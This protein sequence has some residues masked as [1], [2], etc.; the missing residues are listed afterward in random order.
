[1]ANAA[2]AS[3]YQ[4]LSL[5]KKDKVIK[6][7]GKTTSFDYYESLLSPNIT[8]IMTVIDTGGSTEYDS[9]YDSQGRDGAI[10]NGLPLTGDGSEEIRFKITNS[11]GTL[12]F[13]QNPL[14]VN[15]TINPDKESQREAIALNLVS[16][17]AITNQ[18][19]HVLR[20]YSQYTNNGEIVQAISNNLLGLQKLTIEATKN[21]YPLI[22]NDTPPFD[23]ILML[24]AKSAPETGKPGFFFYETKNGHNFR[25][26]DSLIDEGPVATY[27]R[28][29]VNKSS[30]NANNDFK[31]SS[32][33]IHKNQNLIN[34]LKS[35][36][37]TNRRITFD[38]R[39]FS[40]EEKT[41]SIGNMQVSLGKSKVPKPENDK[42]TRTVFSVKD[43]GALGSDVVEGN[44]AGDPQ[45]WQGDIQM[46]YNLLF[47][48]MVHMQVPCNPNL[49][50]GDVVRCELDI[51]SH[52]EKEQGEI[53]PVNSGDYMILDLCHHY[54]PKRSFTSMTLVRDT[55]GLYTNKN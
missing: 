12:D 17:S 22:G 20:N 16:K 35:G 50:A 15:G 1:M 31:I 47:T 49:S 2:N 33:S 45:T 32:F 13:S 11:M 3:N 40:L 53:D 55:Y 34:A 24:A 14:Y 23:V 19:N 9:E 27:Y 52:G 25:S 29:E 37:Y 18:E 4:I 54:D 46:R 39:N 36:V 7:E 38:P 6:L 41:T 48:Q 51:I 30:I 8:A 26:I 28:S 21:K 10:F 5:T 42:H 44:S 43:V